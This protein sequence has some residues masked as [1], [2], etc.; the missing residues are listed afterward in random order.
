MM[1]TPAYVGYKEFK[2]VGA[3]A[4]G[5]DHIGQHIQFNYHPNYGRGVLVDL[6]VTG[7]LRQVY[8]TGNDTTLNLCQTEGGDLFEATLE[9]DELVSIMTKE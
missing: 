1:I 7:E 8:H 6:L 4:L 5:A 3:G 9:H 2:K